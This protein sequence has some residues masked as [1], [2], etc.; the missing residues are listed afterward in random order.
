[1]ALPLASGA[2]TRL[3]RRAANFV[4][5]QWALVIE[6]LEQ[7]AP[8]AH[9]RL[10][11]V[12]CGDKPYLEIFAPRVSEYVGVEH[13]ASFEAT[14][15]AQR[16]R[17]PDVLYDGEH[18][19]FEAHTFDTVL[20]IQTLEH[21]PKPR[22]LVAELARVLKPS[23]RLLL[24]APF[25]F[26]LHEE[27]HDYFRYTPHG[28]RVLCES[29]GLEI[30][31]CQPLGSLWSLLGHK[32]NSYLAFKLARAG[33]IAQRLNKLGHEAEQRAR[34]RSWLLPPVALTMA[35][36][37]TTARVLDRAAPDESESLGFLVV[38]RHRALTQ[39]RS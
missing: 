28:L 11:D 30:E 27:P 16:V 19:P 5:L 25:S 39:K 31:R 2:L 34:P 29:A 21:T 36:V 12:G 1:M 15:S 6:A 35:C 17:G 13:A 24:M 9:G 3:A 38:A 7:V 20:C 10:L 22:E 33:G 37:S 8:L 4:D 14:N 26:R 18:L 23:G 32:F